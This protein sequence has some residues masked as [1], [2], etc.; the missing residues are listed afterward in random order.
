MLWARTPADVDITARH[1]ISQ[2]H[3]RGDFRDGK[4]KGSF[5]HTSYAHLVDVLQYGRQRGWRAQ[6]CMGRHPRWRRVLLLHQL[7]RWVGAGRQ[8][9]CHALH[10][11]HTQTVCV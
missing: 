10:P 2:A 9:R 6:P 3:I 1:S 5:L 8:R 11:L 7:Q 4:L